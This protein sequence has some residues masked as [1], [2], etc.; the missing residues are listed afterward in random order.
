M[1]EW[2][3][4]F[5]HGSLEEVMSSQAKNTAWGKELRLSNRAVVDSRLAHEISPEEYSAS[6]QLHNQ[7]MV[8]FGRRRTILIDA[9]STRLRSTEGAGPR[10]WQRQ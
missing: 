1:Q 2:S 7:D 4:D 8:E 6:R 9:I 5:S 3:E 10:V